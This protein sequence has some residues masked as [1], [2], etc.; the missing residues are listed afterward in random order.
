MCYW[1]DIQVLVGDRRTGATALLARPCGS[2]KPTSRPGRKA[3]GAEG[4]THRIAP[5]L[6][7]RP[8]SVH[9]T[10]ALLSSVHQEAHGKRRSLKGRRRSAL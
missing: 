9:G 10:E 4:S 8:E 7:H 3:A 1:L 5:C 2:G 6:L